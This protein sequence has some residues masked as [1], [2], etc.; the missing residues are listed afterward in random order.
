MVP[1]VFSIKAGTHE[2]TNRCNTLV[3]E[4][5]LCVQSSGKSHVLIA[6]IGCSDKSPGVNASTFDAWLIK[7]LSP[8]HNFVAATC[9]TKLN[10]FDFA[11]HVAATKFCRGNKIFNKILL[12]TRQNLLLRRVAAIC[13]LVCS[14]LKIGNKLKLHN[15][16]FFIKKLSFLKVWS[17]CTRN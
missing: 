10:Q 1:V 11:R 15:R 7:I 14:G 5:A 2:A 12:F 6:A 16:S 8:Q 4:I 3:Q 17:Y 13:R 9:C